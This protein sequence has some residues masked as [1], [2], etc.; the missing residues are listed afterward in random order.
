MELWVNEFWLLVTALIFTI[1]GWRWGVQSAGENIVESTIDAL[2]ADGYLKTKG[3]G[4]DMI[5]L[6]WQEWHNDQDSN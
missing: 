4:A 5:I 6:K 1:V 3:S 2:I